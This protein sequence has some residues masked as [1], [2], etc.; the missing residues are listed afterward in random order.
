MLATIRGAVFVE[1]VSVDTPANVRKAKKAIKAA[2]QVQLDGKGFALVEVLSTC[3]SNWGLSPIE[4][5]EWLRKNMMPYYPLG[6][7]RKPE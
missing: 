3:P 6:N 2:F 7:F 4:A 5:L 1:R